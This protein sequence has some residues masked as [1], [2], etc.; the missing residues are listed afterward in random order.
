MCLKNPFERG[1]FLA[2]VEQEKGELTFLG[3]C[4]KMKI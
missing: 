4:V 1:D 2:L 3:N